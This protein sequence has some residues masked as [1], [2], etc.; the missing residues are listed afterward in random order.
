[1]LAADS[2]VTLRAGKRT[3][4]FNTANKLHLLVEDAPVGVMVSGSPDLLQVPWETIIKLYRQYR[5]GQVLQ[6]LSEY[7]DDLIEFI[8]ERA[9]EYF[10]EEVQR[11]SILVLVESAYRELREQVKSSVRARQNQG[12]EASPEWVQQLI[13]WR[14][15]EATEGLSRLPLRE[16][17][18]PTDAS[19]V[20][21]RYKGDFES[22][23][24]SV[25]GQKRLSAEA[26]DQLVSIAVDLIVRSHRETRR[27]EVVVAGYGEDE[28][29]PS[30]KAFDVQAVA[31]NRLLN[32]TSQDLAIGHEHGVC[33]APFAQRDMIATFMDGA[34][35]DLRRFVY[36]VVDS[37]FAGTAD[38]VVS[39]MPG[40]PDAVRRGLE[41][42]LRS[43]T[44]NL[45]RELKR[46]IG[47]YMN[48]IHAEPVIGTIS[49]LPKEEMAQVAEA[50]VDL[51]SMKR[52]VT[53]EPETVGGPVDVAV[54]S[55]GDGF[56]WVRR[57]HYFDPTLNPRFV[58][59]HVRGQDRGRQPP[60]EGNA[61]EGNH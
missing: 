15:N 21:A 48:R 27:S 38:A 34:S 37:A 24:D 19:E 57:K 46:V 50:L 42:A 17:W 22:V 55:K 16:R 9:E 23:R 40:V 33:I 8:E 51:T 3:K 59:R 31:L 45:A 2:A 36:K 11:Q 52:R 60:K 25:F 29:F 13:D 5:D 4:V 7:A 49:R 20:L 32:Q 43:E 41:E 58:S 56:V 53:M 28:L 18:E 54:I 61:N 44:S 47:G 1:V 12:A 35:P 26:S 10:P 6:H 30:L 39:A 14:V